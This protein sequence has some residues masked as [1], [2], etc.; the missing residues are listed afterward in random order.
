MG[1][2]ELRE[3]GATLGLGGFGGGREVEVDVEEDEGDKNG[4]GA[5]GVVEVH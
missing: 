3:L 5:N 1:F 2:E 4:G